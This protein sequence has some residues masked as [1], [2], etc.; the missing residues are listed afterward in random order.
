MQSSYMLT[1]SINLT[2]YQTTTFNDRRV[3]MNDTRSSYNIYVRFME[4]GDGSTSKSQSCPQVLAQYFMTTLG[5]I[6]LKEKDEIET[7]FDKA[8]ETIQCFLDPTY[9]EISRGRLATKDI[10]K[11]FKDYWKGKNLRHT[12]IDLLSFLDKN[13]LEEGSLDFD[14]YVK[15]MESLWRRLN[16]VNLEK[17]RTDLLIEITKKDLPKEALSFKAEQNQQQKGHLLRFKR[18]MI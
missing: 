10:C 3:E 2:A 16:D 8:L 13:K 14:G 5:T 18:E 15:T 17:T 12:K 11:T 9:E 6:T 4:R 1:V 7:M